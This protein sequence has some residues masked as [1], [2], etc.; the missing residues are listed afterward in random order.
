MKND[1]NVSFQN[2]CAF[3]LVSQTADVRLFSNKNVYPNPFKETLNITSATR[4]SGPV[5]IT[6]KSVD[7]K[8]YRMKEEIVLSLNNGSWQ[9]QTGTLTAGMYI[10]QLQNAEKTE[11]YKLI[12]AN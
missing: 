6:L 3:C 1:N 10:L 4:L 11:T 7:G 2:N 8:V 9:V 12:K 5:H